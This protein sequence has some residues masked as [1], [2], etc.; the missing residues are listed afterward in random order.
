MVPGDPEGADASN[1]GESK[2]RM[3]R[4]GQARLFPACDKL[5][6][7]VSVKVSHQGDAHDWGR[8]MGKRAVC[9]GRWPLSRSVASGE[10]AGET[11]G[12]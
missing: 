4:P 3:C 2:R 5:E 10:S 11:T 9:H 6:N 8:V 7:V 1:L 12:W